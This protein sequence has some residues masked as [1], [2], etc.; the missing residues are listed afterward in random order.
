MAGEIDYRAVF[1]N[2][3][4]LYMLL[5]TDF[6]II[7]ASDAYLKAT[8]TKRGEIV[9]RNLF[10][11]F[12]DSPD[13]EEADGVRNL[14]RS[15]Q[16][17]MATKLPHIMAMQ[18]YDVRRSP[19]DT[20]FEERFWTP[21]NS[22]LLNSDGEIDLIIHR[23]EDVTDF[24]HLQQKER[25][26]EQLAEDMREHALRME[27]DVFMRNKDIERRDVA[28]EKAQEKFRDVLESAPDAMMLLGHDSKITVANA[29]TAKMFGYDKAHL[30]SRPLDTLL[31]KDFRVD[32]KKRLKSFLKAGSNN[33]DIQTFEMY[34]VRESG[35]EFP[36]ELSLSYI[37]SEDGNLAL[38]VI[39]D[40]TERKRAQDKVRDSERRM[41]AI[42]DQAYSC[43][44]AV[45]ADGLVTD[46]NHQAEV[47]FGWTREQA[48]GMGLADTILPEEYKD[49]YEIAM[50]RV[51]DRGEIPILS[52]RIEVMLQN[53]DGKQFPVELAVFPVVLGSD[54]SFCA[55]AAD[56]TERKQ[57]LKQLEAQASDLARSNSELQRF[58]YVAAH[59]LREPLRTIVS[60]T[61]LLAMDKRLGAE[62]DAET[63]EN[64]GFIISAGKRM[65]QLI[66]D[67]LTYSRVESKPH[68]LV[69]TS[70]NKLVDQTIAELK[71]TLDETHGSVT[72]GDLPEIVGDQSQLSQLFLNLIG[73]GLKFKKGTPEIH[74]DCEKR[75]NDWL[76]SIRDNGIGIDM[77]F[78]ERVF[79]MFQRLHGVS[80]YA[81]TGIGLAL[82]KKIVERHRG[83]IWF[84]STPGEGTVFYFTIP[85]NLLPIEVAKEAE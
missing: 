61:S 15:L 46:W 28:I 47:T 81:G 30:Q 13:W 80:E 69:L 65:Q 32:F 3:P 52:R 9:G 44:I 76:F 10:E 73:N 64:M 6:N 16:T 38:T 75:E 57:L 58:A 34:A 21:V 14:R 79:Q 70:C 33:Q 60:Y 5:D 43:F 41:R 53:K 20:V 35:A 31:Q 24:I 7:G 29:Q 82:C 40:I 37:D 59:D 67:L 19:D 12:P 27:A 8:L 63:K 25:A 36:I 66:T 1:E 54:Y 26:Q 22:P 72:R 49:I 4:G 39:R 42:L 51:K 18:K 48:I 77:K 55:F 17:V 83:A 50:Q 85:V 68:S 84:E 45:D 74:I 71:A 78:A 23:V 62:A 56:I 2:L 11:V